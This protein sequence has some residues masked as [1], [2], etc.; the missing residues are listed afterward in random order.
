M[1]VGLITKI[2]MEPRDICKI[3]TR[4]CQLYCDEL[5]HFS[6]VH[7]MEVRQVQQECRQSQVTLVREKG[8]ASPHLVYLHSRE[9]NPAQAENLWMA[10]SENTW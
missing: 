8:F 4:L 3:R 2:L 5:A 9:A 7:L 10:M 1:Q 6:G